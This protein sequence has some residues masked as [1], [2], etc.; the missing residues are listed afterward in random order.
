MPNGNPQI[1]PVSLEQFVR[2][3]EDSGI[4]AGDVLSDFLPPT[5]QPI[6]AEDLARQLIR[7]NLLTKFQAKE[8]YRGRGKSLTL[9]NYVLMDQI[10]SGGMGQVFKARHR[11]M[12]RTVAVK[13]LSAA[14]NK[15]STAISRFEREVKA[16]A[17]LR[18]PNIVAADDADEANGVHFLVMECV[19]GSDLSALVKQNG[20]FAVEQAVNCVLQAARGLEFAH[21]EGVVH[22]DIK[23]ANLLLDK[24]GTVKILDMGLARID[25]G[26]GSVQAELTNT[27]AV[28][29]TVDYMAP[30]QALCAKSADARADIYSLGCSFYYLLTGQAMYEGDTLMAK[31]LAHRDQPL[32]SIRDIRPEASE[33]IEGFFRK[34][35]AKEVANRY[36]TMR[37]V[38]ADLERLYAHSDPSVNT[39]STSD[40]NAD[41]DLTS[42][43]RD[44]SISAPNPRRTPTFSFAEKRKLQPLWIGGG[45]FCGLILLWGVIS[46]IWLNTGTLVVEVNETD[47]EVQVL[48]AE[49]KVEFLRQGE[50]GPITLSVDPGKHRLIIR[51]IGFELYA[52]TFEIKSGRRK[53]IK[54]RLSPIASSVA[55]SSHTLDFETSAFR[56]WR[57]SV[58]GLPAERQVEAVAKRL[59]ELN[60]EF[61]GQLTHSIQEGSVISLAFV[62]DKIRDISPVRGLERL[63]HLTCNAIVPGTGQ[64]ADLSPLSGM[65]LMSLSCYCTRVSDLSPLKGMRLNTLSVDHTEVA[66][67]APLQGMPIVSMSCRVTP[68]SSLVPLTGMALTIL[69]CESTNV[70]DL[71]PL[72]GM[73]LVNLALQQTPVSDL[74]PLVDCKH[75]VSLNAQ[76]TSVSAD[77]VAALQKSLPECKIDWSNPAN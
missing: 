52:T 76:G 4:I 7:K 29:G 66:D 41:A 73:P 39:P 30:E 46:R 69:Q 20:P 27:G 23:P 63:Q 8:I 53:S 72:R 31:L 6:D 71:S 47:V 15:D 36:Q 26:E 11:R 51:K 38:I 37:E 67:L 48:T 56:K 35:V 57:K 17:R 16:A 25:P 42:F 60:P 74:S 18:H 59:V 77:G 45:L 55:L 14:M 58:I 13:L 5:S 43:L 10:G 12:N 34:M 22:R 33:E 24:R 54:V 9:G 75:L 28:M 2:Q 50:S 3:L 61:D 65:S 64:L 1:M 21:G 32:P 19:D 40:S 49:G 44:H 68:V 70:S 62:T